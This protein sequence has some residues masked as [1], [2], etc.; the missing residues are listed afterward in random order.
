MHTSLSNWDFVMYEKMQL[1]YIDM[2]HSK[3]S[4]V[5]VDRVCTCT[6]N[7]RIFHLGTS[8]FPVKGCKFWPMFGTYDHCAV[9]VLKRATPR[10]TRTGHPVIMVIAETISPIAERMAWSCH[11]LFWQ[12]EYFATGI[13]TSHLPLA[14]RTI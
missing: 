11:Y 9:R 7:S 2:A 5:P 12:F 4:R 1:L 8:P 13:R 14:G 3:L 6:S 10:M